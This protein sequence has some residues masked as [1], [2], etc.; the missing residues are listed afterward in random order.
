MI[1]TLAELY[2]FM[3]HF[4]SLLLTIAG[5]GRSNCMEIGKGAVILEW[6]IDAVVHVLFW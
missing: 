2:Q 5:P 1:V 4:P 6:T 3:G